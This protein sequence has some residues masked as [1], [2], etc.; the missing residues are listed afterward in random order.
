MNKFNLPKPMRGKKQEIY[1]LICIAAP[2]M[3]MAT[4]VAAAAIILDIIAITAVAIFTTIFCAAILFKAFQKAKWLYKVSTRVS[5]R[6]QTL[7]RIREWKPSVWTLA[8]SI[9]VA[10]AAGMMSTILML[11]NPLKGMQP[12]QIAYLPLTSVAP[13]FIVLIVRIIIEI[14]KIPKECREAR[15]RWKQSNRT[16]KI[17]GA[18]IGVSALIF[19]AVYGIAELTNTKHL[20]WLTS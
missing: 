14:P 2:K 20:L 7:Q 17:I 11:E 12:E 1:L 19:L 10:W 5:D 9:S 15:V 3:T 6:K 13:M 16:E 4:L 18:I 8:N